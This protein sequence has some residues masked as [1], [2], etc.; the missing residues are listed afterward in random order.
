M[1]AAAEP[2]LSGAE[3][4]LSKQAAERLQELRRAVETGE[5]DAVGQARA[6]V[7]ALRVNAMRLPDTPAGNRLRGALETYTG[8]T[9]AV[10]RRQPTK[11]RTADN[12]LPPIGPTIGAVPGQVPLPDEEWPVGAPAQ[13][14]GA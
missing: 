13:I 12:G 14:P 4:G 7:G 10:R 5:P 8:E 1:L 6:A 9:K 11:P 3:P 2:F